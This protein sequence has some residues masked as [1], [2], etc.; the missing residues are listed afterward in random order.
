MWQGAWHVHGRLDKSNSRSALLYEAGYSHLSS[1]R[2]LILLGAID[3]FVNAIEELLHLELA[4]S[5]PGSRDT[6][7]RS[8]P[9]ILSHTAV[10]RNTPSQAISFPR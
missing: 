8:D 7:S 9:P 5:S 6:G 1:E 2:V 10:Q 3:E 4:H